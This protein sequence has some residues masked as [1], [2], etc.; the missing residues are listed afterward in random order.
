LKR[1]GFQGSASASLLSGEDRRRSQRVVIRIPVTLQWEVSGQKVKF[2]AT[3]VSV[4]DH[5]AMLSC[6]RTIAGDATLD[7]ENGRT[8]EIVNCRVTRTPVDTA[9]GF[10]VPVE[11][12]TAAPDFW[13]ISFPPTNW[14]PLDD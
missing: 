11:F 2:Q 3:T 13:R 14:K 6:P 8:H 1:P 5:G 10:M 7:L 9:E 12:T 4:N